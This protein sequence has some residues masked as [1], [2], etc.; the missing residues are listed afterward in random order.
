MVHDRGRRGTG[1]A[2]F[3]RRQIQDGRFRIQPRQ[4]HGHHGLRAAQTD[5]V[6]PEGGERACRHIKG[7]V[8]QLSAESALPEDHKRILADGHP[9]AAAQGVE[10]A[11]LTVRA[12]YGK[13]SIQITDEVTGLVRCAFVCC[14]E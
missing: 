14:I 8:R 13:P 11:E 4:G 9:L 6:P 2:R 10:A 1:S 12:E 7:P 3:E 5:R